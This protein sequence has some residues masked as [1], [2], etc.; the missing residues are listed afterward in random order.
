MQCSLPAEVQLFQKAQ[1]RAHDEMEAAEKKSSD[2][3]FPAEAGQRFVT[4]ARKHKRKLDATVFEHGTNVRS[5]ET[6]E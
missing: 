5:S 3:R 4:N 6:Q 2:L 1:Q